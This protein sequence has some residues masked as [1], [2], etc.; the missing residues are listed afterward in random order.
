MHGVFRYIPTS[1]TLSPQESL[2]KTKK[3]LSREN[4]QVMAGVL[5]IYGLITAARGSRIEGVSG[6]QLSSVFFGARKSNA[7][8]FTVSGLEVLW[9]RGC[10]LVASYSSLVFLKTLKSEPAHDSCH[11]HLKAS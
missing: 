9:L 3:D 7:H 5:G 4:K 10:W 1:R 11:R 8:K 2:R 6:L